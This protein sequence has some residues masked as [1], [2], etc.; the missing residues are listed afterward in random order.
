MKTN[1][2]VQTK[3]VAAKKKVGLKKSSSK[4]VFTSSSRATRNLTALEN[5]PKEFA[6]FLQQTAATATKQAAERAARMGLP[7]I[8]VTNN[9]IFKVHPDGRRELIK[10]DLQKNVKV[11]SLGATKRHG[12]KK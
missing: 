9:Q 2:R 10:A 8:V 11:K 12:G 7:K 6:T 5:K 4:V 1:T 3:K